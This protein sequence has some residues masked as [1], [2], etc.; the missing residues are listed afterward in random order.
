[1]ILCLIGFLSSI[2]MNI[3]VLYSYKFVYPA[4]ACFIM[5]FAALP[6]LPLSFDLACEL[7]FPIGEALTTG[8]LM[9]GGQIV[10]AIEVFN[11]LLY[12]IIFI[13]R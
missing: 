2:F 12:K 6:L 4:V 11:Y 5:G 7:T 8:L 1:M 3:F 13:K 9:T 10:G